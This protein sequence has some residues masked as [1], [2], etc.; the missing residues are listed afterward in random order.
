MSLLPVLLYIV[1]GVAYGFYFARGSQRTGR[2]ATSSLA[3]AALIHT[4]VI[5]MR[6]VEVGQLPF[7]DLASAISAFVWLLAVAYLYTEVTTDERAMGV[8]IVPLLVVLQSVSAL[9]DRRVVDPAPV[10]DSPWLSVHVA[11]LLVAYA[12][13]A[14][15]CVVGITYVLLFRELKSKRLGFFAERLPSLQALDAMNG[16]AVG[17]GWL[18]LTAG[19]VV[20]AVWLS[21]LQ[22]ETADP[23]VL[24]MS[25]YDPKISVVVLSWLV[26][27]FE[28]YARSAIG[29]GGKRT[30]WLSAGGFSIIL[31]NLVLVRYFTESH[32]F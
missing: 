20:S 5:G 22:P 16:R 7:V 29:W 31:L 18:F 25:F 3:G 6:T 10:L 32:T 13:F 17:V 11:S 27:S 28:L 19:L 1:A 12:A 2:L 21:R 9:S 30:A 15:A 24:A 14:L 23:R 4:F 26:Y 8:F